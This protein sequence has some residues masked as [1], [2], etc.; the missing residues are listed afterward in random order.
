MDKNLLTLWHSISSGSIKQEELAEVLNLSPKQTA[1]N[2]QKWTKEGWLTFISGRGRGNLSMIQWLKNVEDI[3]EEQLMNMIDQEPV[4]TSSKYLL[5]DWS[6][7]SK[8]RLMNKFRSKFGYVQSA[9]EMDKLIIPRRHP[10]LTM[11]PL[12]AAD[13]HSANMVANVF[14]RLVAVD[15]HGVISPELAHSWDATPTKLRL[16]L[17]KDIKFHDGSILNAEDVIICLERLRNHLHYRDLWEPIH[18]I[19]VVAPLIV[20]IYFPSGCSYCLQMLGTMNASIYKESKGHVFGTGS[21]YTEDNHEIKTTLHAFKDYFQERPLLDV[22][23]FV[24]VPR[25][26]DIVYRSTSQEDGNAT[27]Q[28]ESNSGF[29]VVVMNT[30]RNT[31][32]R[33]KEVRDYVHYVIAKHQHEISQVYSRAFPN[34]KSCLIGQD[35]Q[36]VATKVNRPNFKEPL[37]LKVVDYTEKT[38]M[39]LK[40]VLEKEGVPVEIRWLSFE[41][42]IKN[43]AKNQQV[44]LFIHGEVF[45]LNQNFSFYYFLKNGYSPFANIIKTDETVTKYLAEYVHTPFEDWITLNLK[46]ERALMEASIMIPLYYEKRQ[47]PFSADLMNINIK[48][49]GYVDFSKVWV[50]PNIEE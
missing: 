16:Y 4:E 15:E 49:F 11:H 33:R 31:A 18:D 7:D 39:W 10:L 32:I 41:E 29:G 5:F 42:S 13:V 21:F 27:Y 9:N 48:H 47:I 34:H 35:Q 2:I 22:V 8:M 44:D 38:T 45:E 40:E 1:R 14:N 50:R 28:V 24:Q 20:D 36:Y 23:E 6:I 30:F 43:D 19:K 26:F 3:Y 25:D 46:V 37:V 17:K 12:E